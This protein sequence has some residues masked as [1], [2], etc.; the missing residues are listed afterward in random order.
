[1]MTLK[2]LIEFGHEIR[3]QTRDGDAVKWDADEDAY[4]VYDDIFP[5]DFIESRTISDIAPG[6]SYWMRATLDWS[7]YD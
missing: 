3:I 5:A 6:G 4:T 7:I 1:M 2:D